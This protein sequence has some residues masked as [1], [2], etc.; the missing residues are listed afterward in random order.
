MSAA[1]I[2]RVESVGSI[3]EID[4]DDLRYRRWPKEE[5]PREDPTWGDETQGALQDFVWHKMTRRPYT[6]PVWGWGDATGR[7]VIPVPEHRKTTGGMADCVS[8]PLLPAEYERCK[9]I[10]GS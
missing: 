10:Y 6:V 2:V 4:E 7:L 5:S 1:N 3:W 9:E 8:A